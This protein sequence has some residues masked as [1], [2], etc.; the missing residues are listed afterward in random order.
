[1]SIDITVVIPTYNGAERLP[2]VLEKLRS[3]RHTDAIAWD[4][5]VVDNNSSDQTQTVLQ[6]QQSGWDQA[7]ALRSC[8][9]ERQG[10]AYARQRGMQASEGE[11]VAFV[12]DDNWPEDDWIAAVWAFTQ[13]NPRLGAFGG[14]IHADFEMEPPSGFKKIQAFLAIRELGPDPFRF[15]PEQLRLPPGAGLVVRRQACCES[16]P[17]V[18]VLPGRVGPWGVAGEDYEILLHLHKNGWEIWYNPAM[19][20]THHIPQTRLER[21]YLLALA[22]GNGLATCSLRLI[23]ADGWQQP[24]VILK[25]VLGN[26]RRIVQQLLQSRKNSQ[27]DLIAAVEIAFYLGSLMSPF[28]RIKN[29]IKQKT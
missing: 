28:L 14:Q 1:M 29:T 20:L 8:F 24:I 25:T 2:K 17:M 18:P 16:V 27:P 12:D 4:I 3:Q 5:L 21:D 22:W 13:D 15:E 23:T 9:E 11:W 26:L 6:K 7:I 10:L 19:H